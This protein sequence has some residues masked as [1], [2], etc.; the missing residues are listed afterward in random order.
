M[1]NNPYLSV[2]IPAY[3]E[4]KSISKTLLSI[5]EYLTKQH[6]EYEILV[7]DGG[8][9]DKTREIARDFEKTIKNLRL[10]L[11]EGGFSKGHVVKKGILEAKGQYRLFMDADNATTLDH[12]EKMLPYF[13]QNYEVII[14]TRDSRDIKTAKQ[15]VPQSWFKRF[16]GDIGNLMIQVLAVPGIW[17]TQCGFKAFSAKAAETIFSLVTIKG[18]GFDI[19]VLALARKLN[20]RIALIPVYW[21]N[22]PNSRVNLRG[23]LLT[24]L[25]LFQ[26]KWQLM[27]DKYGL[28]AF[29]K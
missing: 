4:E 10:F 21:V 19:E 20:Y 11:V 26:I 7:C 9:K 3:N 29:K 25:E 15:A 14:G 17:D 13:Q 27:T 1:E 6:Y 24:F 28:K 23:Y 22:D 2:I 18:W 8:S 5:D 16:L 12:V